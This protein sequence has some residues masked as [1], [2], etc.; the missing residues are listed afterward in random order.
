MAQIG[1]NFSLSVHGLF[2]FQFLL[3]L[4]RYHSRYPIHAANFKIHTPTD[5]NVKKRGRMLS[6]IVMTC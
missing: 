6:N 2:Q 3:R 5:P 4:R 1:R